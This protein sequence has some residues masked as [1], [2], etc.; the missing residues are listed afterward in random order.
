MKRLISASIALCVVLAVIGLWWNHGSIASATSAPSVAVT[1]TAEE[2]AAIGQQFTHTTT[3]TNTGPD[4]K[5]T[6]EEIIPDG[7]RGVEVVTISEP[8][9]EVAPRI[10]HIDLQL[11]QGQTIRVVYI[12]TAAQAGT[13]YTTAKVCQGQ[14]CT[15]PVTASTKVVDRAWVPITHN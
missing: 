2:V 11:A 14:I 12:F 5:L 7:E 4:T 6:L 3:V 9:T 8:Y 1:K 15:A 13:Y 10:F